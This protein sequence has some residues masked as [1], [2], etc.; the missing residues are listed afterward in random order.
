MPG[1]NRCVL[2]FFREI[3]DCEFLEEFFCRG[4]VCFCGVQL[5]AETADYF[6]CVID[7]DNGAP[8]F[9]LFVVPDASVFGSGVFLFW[10][11]CV[12]CVFSGRG[13]TQVGLAIV[14]AAMVDMIDE[15]ALRDVDNFPV[16]RD[17]YVPFFLGQPLVAGRIG[18]VRPFAELPFVFFEPLV[19]VRVDDGEFALGQWDSPVRVAAAK[20]TVQQDEEYPNPVQPVRNSD[21]VLDDNHPSEFELISELVIS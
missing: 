4:V 18:C 19:V 1:A 9:F 6:S 7:A 13:R 5:I 3:Q 8:S 17:G 10:I 21:D 15:Q 11:T 16:H 2:S 14:Q 20:P 12:L